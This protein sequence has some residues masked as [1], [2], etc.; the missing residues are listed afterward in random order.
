[1]IEC[2]SLT[3]IFKLKSKLTFKKIIGNSTLKSEYHFQ[4]LLVPCTFSM[5]SKWIPKNERSHLFNLIWSGIFSL[6]LGN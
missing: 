1:M 5:V 3:S 6:N 4:G 2:P